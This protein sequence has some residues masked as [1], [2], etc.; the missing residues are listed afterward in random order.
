MAC[1]VAFAF[2]CADASRRPRIVS[3]H[4]M[5]TRCPLTYTHVHSASASR[6]L[7]HSLTLTH[8]LAGVYRVDDSGLEDGSV[9]S[10][11]VCVCVR[12]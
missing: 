6:P 1:K 8:S 9:A 4:S 11:C 7:T 2:R 10:V 12:V 3:V 5:S